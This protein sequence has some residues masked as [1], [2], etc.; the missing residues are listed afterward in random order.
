MATKRGI[1]LRNLALAREKRAENVKK[2]KEPIKAPPSE[3]E[4]PP[5]LGIISNPAREVAAEVTKQ[6]MIAG[7]DRAIQDGAYQHRVSEDRI[8]QIL[9]EALEYEEKADPSGRIEGLQDWKHEKTGSSE[10]AARL[11]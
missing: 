1:L 7:W 11:S 6:A 8:R 3:K 4:K 2:A 5:N 10:L 9:D